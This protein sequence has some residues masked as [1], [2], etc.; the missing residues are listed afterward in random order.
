M[1]PPTERENLSAPL[2]PCHLADAAGESGV[3]PERGVV[4]GGVDD[5]GDQR[6]VRLRHC[7]ISGPVPAVASL[8]D[9][10]VYS[11]TSRRSWGKTFETLPRR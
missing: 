11:R 2:A 9:V 6:R 1:I 10:G 5:A 7:R 8:P 3:L 4:A